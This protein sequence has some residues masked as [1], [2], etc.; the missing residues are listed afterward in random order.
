MNKTILEFNIGLHGE[1]TIKL[2]KDAKVLFVKIKNEKICL[3]IFLDKDKEKVERTFQ[4]VKTTGDANNIDP[5]II[6]SI[7]NLCITKR[8]LNCIKN[9]MIEKDFYLKS[10]NIY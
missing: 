8:Y 10:T 7:D 1:E 9:K 4:V 3:S 2:P 5:E 6:G